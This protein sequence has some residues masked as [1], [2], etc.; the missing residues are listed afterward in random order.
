MEQ[1]LTQ[2]PATQEEKDIRLRI[3]EHIDSKGIK[4]KVLAESIGCSPGHLSN[5]LGQARQL[6]DDLKAK[7]NAH[8]GTEF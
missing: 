1:T 3:K 4:Y 7:L 5:I 6:S 8:L 2:L